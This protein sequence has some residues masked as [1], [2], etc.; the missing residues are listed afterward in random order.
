MMNEGQ[1]MIRDRLDE[2]TDILRGDVGSDYAIG[3]LKGLIGDLMV[4]PDIKLTK[5]Q[6]VALEKNIQENI[7]WAQACALKHKN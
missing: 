5:K 4:N 1:N 6:K 7:E 3:W 2:L